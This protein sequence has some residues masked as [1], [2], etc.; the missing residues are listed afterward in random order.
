MSAKVLCYGSGLNH[1]LFAL[2]LKR[3]HKDVNF[4]LVTNPRLTGSHELS[5][6][7]GSVVV[8]P[9]LLTILEELGM[10]ERLQEKVTPIQYL[11]YRDCRSDE[12]FGSFNLEETC[13]DLLFK[14]AE[15]FSSRRKE[16][17][18]MMRKGF[19]AL[20][21]RDLQEAISEELEMVGV[22]NFDAELQSITQDSEA[23]TSSKTA[24]L[25]GA[26]MAHHVPF[27]KLVVTQYHCP[28]P[29][30][31]PQDEHPVASK[32]KFRPVRRVP[33]STTWQPLVNM[34]II[35]D[36][37][38]KNEEL[39]ALFRNS[40]DCILELWDKQYGQIQ[41][42]I[43]RLES[44]DG[45]VCVRLTFKNQFS[46]L[47]EN[48][49]TKKGWAQVSLFT[50]F[51]RKEDFANDS[52][53]AIL[54]EIAK[55]GQDV[56]RTEAVKYLMRQRKMDTED[57]HGQELIS[58]FGSQTGEFEFAD[59]HIT[60]KWTCNTVRWEKLPAYVVPICNANCTFSHNTLD[61][62]PNYGMMEAFYAAKYWTADGLPEGFGGHQTRNA[63]RMQRYLEKFAGFGHFRTLSFGKRLRIDFQ[64]NLKVRA[65][66]NVLMDW[67]SSD[68][69]LPVWRTAFLW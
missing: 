31:L 18:E 66:M 24:T 12:H 27:D 5:G 32:A 16:L 51:F 60:R 29:Q 49:L 57:A 35:I 41:A 30:E 56:Q 44:A 19:W 37:P 45:P 1:S 6:D 52:F 3:F 2:A 39:W 42:T 58:K 67:Q 17:R 14:G 43:K 13:D 68:K 53:K 47:M 28:L 26:D 46:T 65:A 38:P 40:P 21:M 7:V 55:K 69:A 48:G 64:H 63:K 9:P 22:D 61:L 20:D 23:A 59:M 10:W 11:H 8:S 50:N 34:D 54:S 4:S 36:Q 15:I 25:K 62:G 33:W